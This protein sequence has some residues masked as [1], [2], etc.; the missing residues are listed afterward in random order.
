MIPDR[1][2]HLSRHRRPFRKCLH[3]HFLCIVFQFNER[4]ESLRMDCKRALEMKEATCQE[5]LKFVSDITEKYQGCKHELSTLYENKSKVGDK[6]IYF[7]YKLSFFGGFFLHLRIPI[8]FMLY[9][10]LIDVVSNQTTFNVL[11]RIF[12]LYC[13]K[14]KP[15]GHG[16]DGGK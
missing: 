13:C 8:I 11:D 16:R 5:N 10:S 9:W 2:I 6:W 12:L 4:E 14:S 1:E 15:F 7:T 3:L